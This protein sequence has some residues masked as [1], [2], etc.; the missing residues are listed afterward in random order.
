[1]ESPSPQEDDQIQGQPSPRSPSSQPNGIPADIAIKRSPYA[2]REILFGTFVGAILGM[3]EGLG[4]GYIAN[5]PV[6]DPELPQ[7]ITAIGP[8]GKTVTIK[9]SRNQPAAVVPER[10]IP[11]VEWA[12]LSAI[13]GGLG[14]AILAFVQWAYRGP[15][16][17]PN[18]ATFIGV[19]YGLL[20]GVLVFI[21]SLAYV[22]GKVSLYIAVGLFLS[23]R[24]LACS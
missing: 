4:I 8:D 13:I 7:A 10:N 19:I 18:I 20:P 12:L 24:C 5:A 23:A 16:T 2:R 9:V 3:I 14:G 21:S 17:E 1:M 22:R 11:W 6:V 15:Y